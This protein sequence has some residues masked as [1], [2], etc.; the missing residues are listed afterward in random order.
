MFMQEQRKLTDLAV[1]A[2]I[3]LAP[4][5]A[6]DQVLFEVCSAW[7]TLYSR[8]ANIIAVT[9]Q[10]PKINRLEDSF[11]LWKQVI[12]NKL[13][14]DVNIVLFLNKCDLLKVRCFGRS[15]IPHDLTEPL[16]QCFRQSCRAGC[17]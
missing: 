3:F 13:L 16:R 12:S 2:I 14:A 11:I 5:S 15:T 4:I 10:E 9:S 8:G 1:N 17:D 7:F 6:F